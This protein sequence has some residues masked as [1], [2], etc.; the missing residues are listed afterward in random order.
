MRGDLRDLHVAGLEHDVQPVSILHRRAARSARSRAHVSPDTM[1]ELLAARS[2]LRDA[3]AH[4]EHDDVGVRR[5]VLRRRF[6]STD[7]QRHHRYPS[8]HRILHQ[9]RDRSARSWC[10][11][12]RHPGDARADPALRPALVPAAA[13]LGAAL[14]IRGTRRGRDR[15]ALVPHHDAARAGRAAADPRRRCRRLAVEPRHPPLAAPDPAAAIG[16]AAFGLA[17]H[18]VERFPAAGRAVRAL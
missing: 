4:L 8:G 18:A 14:Q 16:A 7:R 5:L 11:A 1:A 12:L 17:R 6:G 2:A 15:V 13:C 3:A 9:G 10:R